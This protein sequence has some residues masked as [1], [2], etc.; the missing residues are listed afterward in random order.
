M[1]SS[2]KTTVITS[3][4]DDQEIVTT[5]YFEYEV[6]DGRPVSAPRVQ[7]EETTRIIDLD[8]GEYGGGDYLRSLISN[9]VRTNGANVT[10]RMQEAV[11]NSRTPIHVHED[12][13]KTV[14]ING[15]DIT[16]M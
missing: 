3:S 14:R 2:E 13:K 11:L 6:R 7:Y 10:S 15:I 5:E 12:A 4:K 1:A 8:S 16:G 9:Y